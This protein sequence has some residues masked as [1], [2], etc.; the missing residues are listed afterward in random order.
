MLYRLVLVFIILMILS[1]VCCSGASSSF[2]LGK[3]Q[4]R[5]VK[6]K[7]QARFNWQPGL[8]AS[9]YGIV[10]YK[11]KEL[12]SVITL[13]R[14][15]INKAMISGLPSDSKLYWRVEAISSQ[16]SKTWNSGEPGVFATPIVTAG[17]LT[18]TIPRGTAT[19]DGKI[20]PEEWNKAVVMKLNNYIM[21]QKS[22]EDT[23]PFCKL[24]WDDKALYILGEAYFPSGREFQ[25]TQQPRDG[26]IWASDA[27]EITLYGPGRTNKL[28]FMV[29]ATNS[30]YDAKAG[31]AGWNVDWEH[32]VQLR[33]GGMTVVITLPFASLGEVP[34]V[35]SEWR[36][37]ICLDMNGQA[38]V[39]S[40]AKDTAPF[41]YLEHMGYIVLGK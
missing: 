20:R 6:G 27:F 15:D 10:L 2:R 25:A 28:H 5:I 13:K 40:W 18:I 16:G 26:S 34:S 9:S 4:T 11:D 12:R 35:G 24:M 36:G 38:L 37:N 30:I 1:V 17:K 3:A 22:E 33:P 31:D 7:V 41:G 8:G 19:M 29:N 14:V 23:A 21:G 39:P 32:F